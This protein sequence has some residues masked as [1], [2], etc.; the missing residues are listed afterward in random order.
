MNLFLL[1]FLLGVEL[2]KASPP[3]FDDL[4]ISSPP[5]KKFLT[6]QMEEYGGGPKKNYTATAFS[7]STVL[8]QQANKVIYWATANPPTEATESQIGLLIL[9][10]TNSDGKWVVLQTLP[11]KAEGKDAEAKAE[12]TSFA[13][14]PDYDNPVVTVSLGQGGRGYSYTESFTYSLN[15]G[16]LNLCQP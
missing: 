6:I 14:E 4:L 3:S 11:F 13:S 9:A 16:R 2:L 1:A 7:A 5:L 8:W 12:L 15:K 10:E